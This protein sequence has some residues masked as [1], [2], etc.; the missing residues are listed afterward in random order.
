MKRFLLPLLLSVVV[1]SACQSKSETIDLNAAYS[2]PTETDSTP[3]SQPNQIKAGDSMDYRGDIT[4]LKIEDPVVGT[5]AEVKAGDTV[6]VHYTGKF[7]DG[8]VFDTSKKRGQPIS[9]PIGVGQVIAGW[10]QGIVGM[11]VGGTR[12]LQIPPE[13]AYGARPPAGLPANASMIFEVELIEIQ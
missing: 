7:I 2:T 12:V 1:L 5:G 13:L 9:F 10:D 3:T 6:L 11:K 4:E 8:T